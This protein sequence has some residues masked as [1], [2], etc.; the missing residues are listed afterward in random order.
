MMN[1]FKDFVTEKK[2][3]S[4]AQKKHLDVDDDNDIDGK[5]FA[6]LRAKKQQKDRAVRDDD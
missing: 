4:P 2:E 1:K 5:D 3:L 6:K